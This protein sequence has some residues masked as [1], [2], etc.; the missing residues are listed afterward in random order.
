MR[1]FYS[2]IRFGGG[3]FDAHGTIGFDGQVVWFGHGYSSVIYPYGNGGQ[4]LGENKCLL[5]GGDTRQRCQLLGSS[6]SDEFDRGVASAMML[7]SLGISD[8]VAVPS[9][10]GGSSRGALFARLRPWRPKR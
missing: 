10:I 6:E 2:N 1:G 7:E 4:A 5:Y 3:L 8:S 9:V